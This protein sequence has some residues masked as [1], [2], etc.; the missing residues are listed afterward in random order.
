MTET[1]FCPACSSPMELDSAQLGQKVECSVCKRVVD[2]IRPKRKPAA[3]IK[4]PESLLFPCPACGKQISTAAASCPNCGHRHVPKPEGCGAVIV[5]WIIGII[6]LTFL[7]WV[8]NA[9]F[10]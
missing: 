3:K 7:G 5:K 4:E 10:R 2:P 6:L 1:C 8:L 9:L